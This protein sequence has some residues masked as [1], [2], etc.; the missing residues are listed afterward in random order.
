MLVRNKPFAKSAHSLM[1]STSFAS[2]SD[3]VPEAFSWAGGASMAAAFFLFRGKKL[4]KKLELESAGTSS[5]GLA[6][7]GGP[8]DG[9]GLPVLGSTWVGLAALCRSFTMAIACIEVADLASLLQREY[10]S[11]RGNNSIETKTSV[12]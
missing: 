6:A 9:R 12:Q 3:S 1:T 10:S 2:F 4:P 5:D 8:D 7:R 11:V